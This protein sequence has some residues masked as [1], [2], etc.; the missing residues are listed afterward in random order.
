MK[1]PTRRVVFE[2]AQ[3]DDIMAATWTFNGGEPWLAASHCI[4]AKRLD[5]VGQLFDPF[6]HEEALA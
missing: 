6:H 5:L 4:E 3:L 2:Q 1:R